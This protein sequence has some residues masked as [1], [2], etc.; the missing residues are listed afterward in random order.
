MSGA[1]SGAPGIARSGA[2]SV[3][4]HPLWS[5]TSV[6]CLVALLAPLLVGL[7]ISRSIVSGT[8][9]HASTTATTPQ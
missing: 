8:V 6:A 5:F 4:L 3:L 7:A 9:V 1:R 2:L